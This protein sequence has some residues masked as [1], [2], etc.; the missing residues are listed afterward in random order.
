MQQEKTRFGV[1]L[2]TF[3]A[4]RLKFETMFSTRLGIDTALP[5]LLNIS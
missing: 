1:M 5:I 4:L 3:L 2:T